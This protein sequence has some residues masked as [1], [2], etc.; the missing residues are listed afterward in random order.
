[1]ALFKSDTV[2][3]GA[4]A[5]TVFNRL[6]NLDNLKAALANVPADQIPEDKREMFDAVRVSADEISFPA[7]PVGDITLRVAEKSPFSIIRLEGVG[8]P[9]PLSLSLH[10]T[11]LG[12]SRCESFIDID[13]AV[14]AMLKPMIGGPLQKLVDQFA[15]VLPAVAR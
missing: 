13:I 10:L 15:Q 4:S 8:T 7:G 9:V 5:E 11:P 6:S 3:L 12:E 1:M 2:S 14:P